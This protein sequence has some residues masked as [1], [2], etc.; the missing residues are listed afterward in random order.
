VPL[1]ASPVMHAVIPAMPPIQMFPPA[2]PMSI[3][4]IQLTSVPP[5]SMPPV[6]P[7]AAKHKAVED[8]TQTVYDRSSLARQ[9]HAKVKQWN[10]WSSSD[11][12]PAEPPKPLKSNAAGAELLPQASH[13]TAHKSSATANTVTKPASSALALELCAGSGTLTACL[14]DRGLDAFGF[15]WQGNRFQK[16]APIITIDLSLPSAVATLMQILNSYDVEFVWAGLPCGTCSRARERPVAAALRRKGAPQPRQ[17]RN[18]AEPHG[19]S[20]LRPPMTLRERNMVETA[21]AIYDNVAEFLMQCTWRGVP[22]AIENP[23]NSWLWHIP[24][25]SHLAR[26]AIKVDFHACMHG[27]SRPKKTTLLTTLH[28]LQSLACTCDDLHDH[29]PW[30]VSLIGAKW[31]FST[32][33]EACYPRLL[34]RRIAEIVVSCLEGSGYVFPVNL[35]LDSLP[36]AKSARLL[37]QPR[38]TMPALVSEYST[39]V[40]MQVS[41]G[42]KLNDKLTIQM[43]AEAR[44]G[45]IV[46]LRLNADDGVVDDSRTVS[47]MVGIFRT[48]AEFL[49]AAS[50]IVH[51]VDRDPL[52]PL[53]R[54]AVTFV[55]SN[56]QDFVSR[57]RQDFV[58]QLRSIVVSTAGAE[59]SLHAALPEPRRCVL[60]GK[61]LLALEWMRKQCGHEDVSLMSDVQNGFSLTGIMPRSGAF[62][63]KVRLRTMTEQQLLASAR[64]INACLVDR[65]GPSHDPEQDRAVASETMKEL[66]LRWLDGPYTLDEMNTRY[67]AGWVG[68]RRFAIFQGC[69]WRVIDD[70]T[71][72]FVNASYELREHVDLLGVEECLAL[73]C[74]LLKAMGG[75]AQLVGRTLDLKSAYRQLPVADS[76][77]WCSVLA[78]FIDGR[79]KYYQQ[80]ALPFGSVASVVAFNRFSRFLW[81][82]AVQL[83]KIPLTNYVDDFPMVDLKI[84]AASSW[85]TFESMLMLTGV[86][87]ATEEKKRK[88][89]AEVFGFLGVEMDLSSTLEGVIVVRNTESRVKELTEAIDA[90]MKADAMKPAVARSL[91]GRLTFAERQVFG[92]AACQ[93][94]GLIQTRANATS[95]FGQLDDLLKASLTWIQQRLLVS[96]P[97]SFCVVDPRPPVLIFT[98][99]AAEEKSGITCGAICFDA[100]T[101]TIEQF[102]GLIPSS[103]TD[104]WIQSGSRQ[105]IHQAELYPAVAARLVWAKLLKHR[106]VLVF[107]DNEAARVALIKGNSGNHHSAQLVWSFHDMDI[108]QQCR[109]WIARVPSCSNPADAPSRLDFAVNE[110]CFGAVTFPMPSIE[111]SAGNRAWEAKL[112]LF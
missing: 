93:V 31:H 37:E 91:V 25:I 107:V 96:P 22:W 21:N 48:P 38:T 89:F 63:P 46:R 24:R 95:R 49:Q 64:W 67:P 51:P 26:F 41:S 98:D 19:M 54:E 4:A 99:G 83:G 71:E 110:K 101:N 68:S 43:G 86:S 20:N 9:P 58:K 102:G 74:Q 90:I 81:R 14:R 39:V 50:I 75:S 15:D 106:K 77:G 7:S 92:G 88:A 3:A 57:S 111:F 36:A 29:L 42:L 112:G 56:S 6:P 32:A 33:D 40:E 62:A 79:V 108:E 11:S 12:V 76:S 73:G 61:K 80:R 84:H 55:T 105:V 72:S 82:C 17:L 23:T 5:P 18:A 34:C 10:K 60:L 109:M 85:L 35:D 65:M 16:Q 28:G 44:L 52:H 47:A 13:I 59:A 97:R 104:V 94:I 2:M 78:V 87:Y 53:L 45:K 103:I 69:K 8:K 27:G 1:P 30:G 66:D 70:F 100:C